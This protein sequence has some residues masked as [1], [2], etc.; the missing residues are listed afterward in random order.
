MMGDE[1]PVK[2]KESTSGEVDLVGMRCGDV[3]SRL[4]TS[5]GAGLAGCDC[6][7]VW[8]ST[9]FAPFAISV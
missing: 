2:S 5:G 8:F 3:R 7:A 9:G 6:G 4:S 1:R